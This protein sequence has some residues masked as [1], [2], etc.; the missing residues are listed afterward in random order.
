MAVA[1]AYPLLLGVTLLLLASVG[2]R[3]W[4]TAAGLYLPRLVFAAPLPVLVGITYWSGLRPLLWAQAVALVLLVPLL[5]F[6]LPWPRF[7]TTAPTI[8]ILSFNVDSARAGA[9]NVVAAIIRERPDVVLLQEVAFEDVD[10]SHELRA[11]FPYV[12]HATQFTVASRFPIT[13]AREV[14]AVDYFGH[15]RPARAMR[16]LIETRLGPIALYSVHPISPRGGFHV[17]RFHGALEQL[18]KGEL[19]S[20]DQEANVLGNAAFRRLQLAAVVLEAKGED[21]PVVIAGDTNLPGLSPALR[22]L[23]FA[24]Q[25]G[26]VAASW[27][28]GYTFPTKWPFMRLD[29]IFASSKLRFVRFEI[30]C[31]GASDHLCV[32]ADLTAR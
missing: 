31:A 8:R 29:R 1:L 6:V 7:G 25:D 27:G 9:A 12:L 14:E 24:Y 21:V 3:Y 11:E 26:F 32:W 23:F 5:G 18:G 16:Y 30:G 22:N 13:A 17:Y 19:F 20:K 28:L 4:L 2:E 15:K 10:L